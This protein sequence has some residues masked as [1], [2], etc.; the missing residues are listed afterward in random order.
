MNKIQNS[1]PYDLEET[2]LEEF[3]TIIGYCNLEL[4]W[5]LGF[6]ILSLFVIWFL[7]FGICQHWLFGPK[8]HQGT[9]GFTDIT[10]S[11]IRSIDKGYE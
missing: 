1:K 8:K 7:R 4:I 2:T 6:E 11:V 5:N 10:I 3:F 9:H